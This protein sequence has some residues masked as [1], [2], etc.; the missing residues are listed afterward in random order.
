MTYPNLK[1]QIVA[2]EQWK[3]VI[4]YEEYYSVSSIGNV[5]SVR[6]NNNLALSY[7]KKGGYVS[8]ELNVGGKAKR[9]KVHRLVAIAFLP[10]PENKST[11]NHKNS[12]RSDN[13]VENLEWAT[14][15]ENILHAFKYGNKDNHGEKHSHN[16]LTERD[17]II[18]LSLKGKHTQQE[19][20]D[21]FK[22]SRENISRIHRRLSWKNIQG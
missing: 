19:I 1:N 12:I 15:S 17:V 13:R 9:V 7:E 16:K 11:V 10:N 6:R 8:V 5:Y 20:A 14:Q 18:I 2:E 22:V 21:M 4:G 3:P